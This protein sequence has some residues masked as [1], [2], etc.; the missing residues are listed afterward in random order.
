M[1]IRSL[2]LLALCNEDTQYTNVPYYVF[3]LESQGQALGKQENPF[4][5]PCQGTVKSWEQDVRWL[6]GQKNPF[7]SVVSHSEQA[8]DPF[9]RGQRLDTNTTGNVVLRKWKVMVA[10]HSFFFTYTLGT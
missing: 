3:P 6:T 10:Y 7:G 2:D 8:E 1:T 5:L 9:L 4:S